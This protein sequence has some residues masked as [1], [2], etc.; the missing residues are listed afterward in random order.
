[1]IALAGS[2]QA[3]LLRRAPGGPVTPPPKG[4]P[5]AEAEI[6][7]FPPPDPKAWWDD[8]RPIAPEA[9]DPLG[10]RRQDARGRPVAVNNGVDPSTYRLWGLRPLQWQL[11]RG[12]EMILE[13]W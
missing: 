4:T 5:P 6:W 11:L 8:K 1:M 10:G 7:P 2:A 3:Q 9:A 12:Q 13:V